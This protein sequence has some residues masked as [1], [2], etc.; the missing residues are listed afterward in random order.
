V[1]EFSYPVRPPFFAMKFARLAVKNCVANAHGPQVFTLLIAIAT[2]E[3]SAKY[4]RAVN[5]YDG[6]LMPL[7]GANSQDVLAKIRQRAIASGWLAY[8]PGRKGVPAEYYVTVPPT[9]DGYSDAPADDSPDELASL[10][11][12]NSRTNR[13]RIGGRID[14]ESA[15]NQRTSSTYTVPCT[16]LDSSEPSS[17]T[18]EPTADDSRKPQTDKPAETPQPTEPP[19]L[20]FP[21]VGDPKVPQWPLTA[22]QVAEWS[23]AYPGVD[24]LAES[25]KALAWVVANPSKRKTARGMPKFLLSWIARSNNS[26]TAARRTVPPQPPTAGANAAV[27]R[28]R[29][30]EMAPPMILSPTNPTPKPE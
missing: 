18:A 13:R 8:R 19:L 5:Y 12:A 2:T 28:L 11:S 26:C 14:D 22:A 27:E 6:Q 16:V 4:K 29:R 1:A 21:V 24:V 17:T 30:G 7:I 25:R 10:S 9:A 3:D 15:E 23:A 20:V